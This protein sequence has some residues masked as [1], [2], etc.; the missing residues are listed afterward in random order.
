MNVTGTTGPLRSTPPSSPR[1]L[2][3]A[4]QSPQKNVI[5]AIGEAI[6]DTTLHVSRAYLDGKGWLIGRS[7]T[8]EA[9]ELSAI[10]ETF[11]EKH[12]S[13]GGAAANTLRVMGKL[14]QLKKYNQNFMF[15]GKAGQDIAAETFAKSLN[16]RGITAKLTES[17]TNHTTRCLCFV[18]EDGERTM[19]CSSGES[20]QLSFSDI[21]VG[22]TDGL[23]HLHF[24]AYFAVPNKETVLAAI[25]KAKEAGATI[26]FDL[27]N[28]GLVDKHPETIQEFIKLS[29][30]VFGNAIE[31][32]SLTGQLPKQ[33]VETIAKMCQIAVISVGEKGA[34]VYSMDEEQQKVIRCKGRKT[35]SDKVKDTT[36]AGD[37]FQGAFLSAWLNGHTLD[38]CTKLGNFLGNK[39]IKIP[40]TD[41]T[42]KMWK[43]VHKKMSQKPIMELY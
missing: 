43:K 4:G 21:E 39:V 8:A 27:A 22:F 32:R 7:D 23:K 18:T 34:Y 9:Q 10:I 12:E 26:S 17:T 24:D 33:A 1:G 37:T 29:T 16:K 14:N 3:T 6:I 30:I 5:A 36:G 11:D 25:K 2:Q 19:I 28:F 35:Q 20:T 38:E 42:E 13:P 31:A 41:L 15:Y 40:G